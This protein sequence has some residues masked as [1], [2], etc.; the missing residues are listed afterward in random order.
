MN[1]KELLEF[2]VK[3]V[4]ESM[5]ELKDKHLRWCEAKEGN[6]LS[7]QSEGYQ[8]V[9]TNDKAKKSC[10]VSADGKIKVNELILCCCPQDMYLAR[11]RARQA[12]AQRDRKAKIQEM[13]NAN[14]KNG[15]YE[16]T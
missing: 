11:E 4:K 15:L 14:A 16:T 7:R 8:P 10:T 9:I 2:N 12:K 1:P 6:M 5:P 13:V 3:A